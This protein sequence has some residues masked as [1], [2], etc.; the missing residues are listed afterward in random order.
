MA[1]ISERLSGRKDPGG[2]Q[3]S[4]ATTPRVPVPAAPQNDTEQSASGGQPDL[5]QLKRRLQRR[6]VTELSPRQ[7]L[8]SG[9]Q[10]R[11]RMEGLFEE[12]LEEEGVLLTRVERSRLF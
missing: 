11:R 5:W 4:A 10:M 1:S 8:N 3:G 2:A 12:L 6:L 7:D 9:L